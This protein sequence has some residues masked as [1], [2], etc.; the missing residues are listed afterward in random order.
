M[1][2]WHRRIP[3]WRTELKENMN[4]TRSIPSEGVSLEIAT[5]T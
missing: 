5:S 3:S 2:S 4:E 1:H